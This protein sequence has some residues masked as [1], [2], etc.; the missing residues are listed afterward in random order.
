MVVWGEQQRDSTIHIYVSIL[1]QTP[2]PS[3]WVEFPLLY[4]RS[5]LVIHYKCCSVCMSIIKSLTTPSP[6]LKAC[7]FTHA[8]PGEGTDVFCSSAAPNFRSSWSAPLSIYACPSP[9]LLLSKI[10]SREGDLPCHF[11]NPA[12]D[13]GNFKRV[14]CLCLSPASTLQPGLCPQRS[15]SNDCSTRLLW[16]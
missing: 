14:N 7:I 13:L 10:L 16:F 1:S 11:Q 12:F 4:S 9:L 6:H 15:T 8:L 5:L 3:H 2:L